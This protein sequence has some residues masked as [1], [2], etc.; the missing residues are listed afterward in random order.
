MTNRTNRPHGVSRLLLASAQTP[1]VSDDMIVHRYVLALTPIATFISDFVLGKVSG[2]LP[3]PQWE[4]V[5][6]KNGVTHLLEATSPVPGY[7]SA[8]GT[9]T[10]RT[11]EV[12]LFYRPI[13]AY[14]IRKFDLAVKQGSPL[15][16]RGWELV[17][18]HNTIRSILVHEWKHADDQ[19][20]GTNTPY[21]GWYAPS[22]LGAY[23]A[24]LEHA[25]LGTLEHE[26]TDMGISGDLGA[27]DVLMPR[28][29][30]D[31]MLAAEREP[32]QGVLDAL[33]HMT[34]VMVE[35]G[36]VTIPIAAA[37]ARVKHTMSKKNPSLDTSALVVPEPKKIGR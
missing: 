13:A 24:Q 18:L 1:V 16:G 4:P 15:H 30:D 33:V 31:L 3:V 34:K 22:E 9:F 28:G 20:R 29:L 8:L 37:I 36:L 11:N 26:K 7:E 17:F 32:T 23:L 35:K 19:S 5:T 25:E 12:H 27:Q 6:G 21:T 10:P 2:K 14:M